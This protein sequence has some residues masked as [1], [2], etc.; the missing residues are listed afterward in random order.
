MLKKSINYVLF[1]ST[2]EYITAVHQTVS[3][4]KTIHQIDIPKSVATQQDRY[5]RVLPIR[6]VLS[7]YLTDLRD[8]KSVAVN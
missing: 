6:Q 5:S 3:T 7:S 2:K 8:S 4:M 1:L